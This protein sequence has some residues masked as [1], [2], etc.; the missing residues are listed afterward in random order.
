[1][2]RALLEWPMPEK[3]LVGVLLLAACSPHPRAAGNAQ[4]RSSATP[5]A[6]AP[7]SLHIQGR[8]S[9]HREVV[10]IEQE[11]NRIIYRLR[12]KTY[13]STVGLE[14]TGFKGRF[15]RAHV[16]FFERNGTTLVA[17]APTALVDKATQRVTLQGG[18]Q[19]RTSAGIQLACNTLTYE[20][21]S[22]R[23]R[24]EGNVRITQPSQGYDIR[25]GNFESDVELHN[26]RMGS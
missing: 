19:G 1:M 12:A 16:T 14:G 26:V 3:L 20:R 11:K 6:S 8:G 4:V 21:S 10:I 17:E 9:A 23:I 2:K 13:E 22:G 25:G 7:P 18:V 24:G 5:A 15:S